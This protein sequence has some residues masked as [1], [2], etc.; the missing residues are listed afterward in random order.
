MM[1]VL[2]LALAP[3]AIQ[4]SVRLHAAPTTV[5][6]PAAA[7][8]TFNDLSALKLSEQKRQM[9]AG[10]VSACSPIPNESK[11]VTACEVASY[12]CIDHTGPNETP[13]DTEKCQA[14]VLKLFKETKGIEK[15]EE[16]KEEKKGAAKKEEKK[17]KMFLQM[18]NI[19]DD[20]AEAAEMARLEDQSDK[21]MGEDDNDAQ[22]DDDSEKSDDEESFVQ[23][24]RK[25]VDDDNAEA[26]EMARLEAQSDK[27]MGED[28]DEAKS[29]ASSDKEDDSESFIEVK[30]NIDDE[31]AEAAEMARL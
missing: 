19:D 29:D 13:E 5:A 17:A 4:A 2:L 21:D 24:N 23:V 25:N 30:R 28:D 10:C 8:V 1:R 15:K 27:D 20:N 14:K 26:A 12:K 7:K 16:K 18:K 22:S 11:C 31:N 3:L 9:H 6:K